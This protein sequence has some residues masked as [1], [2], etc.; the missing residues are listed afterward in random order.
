MEAEIAERAERR[1]R[2]RLVEA[3]FPLTKRL[4]D[5]RFDDNPKIPVAT[6]AAL[7]DGGYLDDHES[8]IL[9]GDSGSGKTHLATALGIRACS[10][11]RRVRFTTLAALVNDLQEADSRRVS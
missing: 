2:R 5:F 4:E 6:I 9:I 10:Q 3:R 11:G 7:A 1:E 8:V